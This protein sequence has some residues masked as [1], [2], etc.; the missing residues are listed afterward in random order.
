MFT[1]IP[2]QPRDLTGTESHSPG[3]LAQ[4]PFAVAATGPS[5]ATTALSPPCCTCHG[6]C[7]TGPGPPGHEDFTG[8]TFCLRGGLGNSSPEPLCPPDWA[9]RKKGR[10]APSGA[11]SSPR[12]AARGTGPG[13]RP[14]PRLPAYQPGSPALET[15]LPGHVKHRSGST[16]TP[17]PGRGAVSGLKC[18]QRPIQDWPF[19]PP[20]AARRSSP[21]PSLFFSP[22]GLPG[23]Q[24]P[25]L[26][27]PASSPLSP[28]TQ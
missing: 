24:Q 27:A 19:L 22:A 4:S 8:Q 26:P 12:L 16:P 1:R 7:L 13:H 9:W 14:A 28:A 17:S 5:Q 20:Q 15:W 23:E 3:A 11:I 18:V 10:R 21:L 2:C 6:D 25:H